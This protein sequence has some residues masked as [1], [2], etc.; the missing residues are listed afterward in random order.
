MA[1]PGSDLMTP[2]MSLM[3]YFIPNDNAL[4]V[5]LRKAFLFIW[6]KSLKDRNSFSFLLYKNRELIP[7]RRYTIIYDFLSSPFILNY[8]MK[9]H[10][11]SSAGREE[12]NAISNKFYDDNFFYTSGDTNEL[13][14][15]HERVKE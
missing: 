6:I 3:N 1:N 11:E 10:L 14:D 7:K 12:R 8:I 5:E 9:N 4:M 15:I 2:L 13:I